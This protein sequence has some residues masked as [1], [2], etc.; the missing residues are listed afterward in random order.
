MAN[1]E[2]RNRIGRQ[3]G[4]RVEHRLGCDV[5]QHVSLKDASAYRPFVGFGVKVFLLEIKTILAIEVAN[6]R[7]ELGHDLKWSLEHLG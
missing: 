3:V 1:S 2:E 7:S 6:R 4:Q 5:L